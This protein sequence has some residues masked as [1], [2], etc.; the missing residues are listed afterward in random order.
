MFT[1]WLIAIGIESICF[2]C[3][4]VLIYMLLLASEQVD[5]LS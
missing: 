2:H 3:F 1:S 4:V 5:G